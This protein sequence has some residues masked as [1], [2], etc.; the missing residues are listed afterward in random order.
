MLRRCF[1]C[2]LA[3]ILLSACSGAINPEDLPAT[4]TPLPTTTAP[5]FPVVPTEACE[6]AR[7]P[8]LR[9]RTAQG[10]LL[11]W[12]NSANSLAFVGP[13]AQSNWY[14]G[15]LYTVSEPGFQ[16]PLRQSGQF[17][18]FGS[19]AWAPRDD[20]VAFIIFRQPER[21]SL[22][23]ANLRSNTSREF[24]PESIPNDQYDSAKVV[25]GWSDEQSVR[26][27]TSCGVDCDQ[28][29]IA[30]IESGMADP[31]GEQLRKAPD[32]LQ[33]RPLLHD[34]DPQQFP[35]MVQET[36]ATRL[37][38]QM[39][40]PTWTKDGHKVAYIDRGLTAWVILVAEE[41]QYMLYTPQ[42]DAQEMKWSA[43]GRYLA[44]RTDDDVYVYD[45][46]CVESPEGQNKAK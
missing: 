8:A 4:P 40:A 1:L 29:I 42:V 35:L 18:V 25:E 17:L 28:T 22:A 31:I 20:Q 32:R 30:N 27:L 15:V 26:F 19:L 36:W 41:R 12:A 11:A 43:D 23:V 33:P 45:T 24:P 5:R 9:T 7:Y 10:D 39:K 44:L 3:V 21:Y 46:E 14:T 34:Y 6:L 37:Y 2:L 38:P 16:D 13:S